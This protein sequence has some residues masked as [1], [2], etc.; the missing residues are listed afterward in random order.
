MFFIFGINQGQKEIGNQG[1]VICKDCGA[2]GRYRVY[3]TYMCLSLF[4]I[5][6]LKWSRK[7]YVEA[8]CCHTVYALN[9]ETGKQLSR[10]R[11]AEIRPED[12]ELIRKGR[13]AAYGGSY[14][15]PARI[16]RCPYCG[17]ETEEDFTFC[18]KCGGRLG[19]WE[20]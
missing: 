6:V 17:F 18:P 11:Q 13:T 12:L 5:P 14:Q 4:F 20:A 8:A 19:E 1:P 3:M 7:Y 10:G 16:M 9:P 2:Y 15:N